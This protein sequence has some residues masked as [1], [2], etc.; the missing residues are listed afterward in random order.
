MNRKY[1]RTECS[2][3]RECQCSEYGVHCEPLDDW[4]EVEDT[5]LA[6]GPCDSECHHGWC[7]AYCADCAEDGDFSD[8]PENCLN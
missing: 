7:E 2:V 5:D 3:C 6:T 4:E 1:C 8:C